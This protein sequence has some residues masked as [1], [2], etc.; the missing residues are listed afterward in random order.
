MKIEFS[1]T[2]KSTFFLWEG[3]H[4]SKTLPRHAY[5]CGGCFATN[6]QYIILYHFFGRTIFFTLAT[7]LNSGLYT[8]KKNKLMNCKIGIGSE[9][10]RTTMFNMYYNGIK[11][12]FR[13]GC[14]GILNLNR[15]IRWAYCRPI[16][17]MKKSC[18]GLTK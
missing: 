4:P 6:G 8:T 13:N 2:H 16:Q 5:T 9:S 15:K 1:S 7:P 14:A 10:Q 17:S 11:R 3:G 18:L 12:M